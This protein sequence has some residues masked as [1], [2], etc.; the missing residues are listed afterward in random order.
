MDNTRESLMAKAVVFGVEGEAGLWVA[1]LESGT[2][3][4]IDVTGDLAR[5]AE[6]RKAG[7]TFAKKVDFAIAVASAKEAFSGHVVG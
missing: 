5:V 1:D 6:I 7:G 3:K 4:P 2:V